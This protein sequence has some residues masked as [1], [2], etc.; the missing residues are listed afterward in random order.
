MPAKGQWGCE[1]LPWKPLPYME[2][3][4]EFLE[5]HGR[6]LDYVRAVRKG[7][8]HFSI[9]L[10]EEGVRHPDEI[11]RQVILR[12][13]AHLVAR[14]TP[15]GDPLAP[16]YR[17]QLLSYARGWIYWLIDQEHIERNPWVRI[18]I[19]VIRKK[20]KPLEP[21]EVAALFEAHRAQAFTIPPF[22]FHR[23]EVVLSLLLAWGLRISELRSLTVTKMDMRQ[24]WIVVRN[25]GGGEKT[26]PWGDELKGVVHRYLTHR[27]RHASPGEDA[28]LIDS[29]G[30]PL[31]EAMVRK[32][33]VECGA[34]AGITINPHRLRDTCGTTLLDADVPVEQIMKIL[35]HRS[36]EQTLA[37]SRV[38]DPKVKASHE[39]VMNPLLHNLLG[40]SELP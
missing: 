12:Y 24:E 27:V 28:L 36:R 20:P 11:T 22:F 8:T 39:A 30:K 23:R 2:E 38:S 10:N 33:I 25:K 14:T 29:L 1:P 19:G 40:E 4:L 32:I 18:R 21:D 6:R 15:E 17:A 31:S 3:Y 5:D 13:Q 16:G 37:Y 34:R 26:L 9:F 35:G 7:M